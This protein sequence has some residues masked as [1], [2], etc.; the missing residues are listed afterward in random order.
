LRRSLRVR[1]EVDSLMSDA[2][3]FVSFGG[4][5]K[6]EDVMPFL[7]N[8]TR[9]RGVPRER[10]EIVAEHYHHFGGKSPINE[11]N[12]ALI[13]A[14][15]R[16]LAEHGPD[17]PVYFG[18]RNWMP[19]L[20]ETLRQ[21]KEDGVTRAFTFVTSAF[22]CY[23]GCRQ[24]R[25]NVY[26]AQAEVGAEGI[27]IHKIRVFYNHP[28]FIEPMVDQVKRSLAELP[29][30][31]LVFTAHSVPL[32]MSNGSDYVKQLTEAAR[33][34]AEGAGVGEY[35]FVYQSRSGAPGQPW[36]EPDILDHM[37]SLN[38]AGV[39]EVI[40][41]PIGFI[42][43]HMEVLFDLDEEARLLAAEL[44]MKMQ[45]SGTAAED[46]RFAA[47][48]RELVLERRGDLSE[49]RA[50]GLY[51]PNHDVCPVDCCTPPPARPAGRPPVTNPTS[52]PQ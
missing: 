43:D 38:E 15:T 27:E 49:K 52:S 9:G 1:I 4:P 33:L 44:G 3:L 50:L 7:E 37:R 45:R 20:P 5:D 46:P 25:E 17:L 26:A 10:L 47:M 34:V 6:P 18:N 31:R 24:Y 29:G 30:G 32:W 23:S 2:I 42:S 51:G 48:I 8:V 28:G 11:Q 16:Q 41:S 19:M 21:M 35:D 40:L 12:L 14:L 22:S 13:A 39:K 36:L